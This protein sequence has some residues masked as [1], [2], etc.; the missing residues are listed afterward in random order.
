[1][2]KWRAICGLYVGWLMISVSAA[3]AENSVRFGDAA[4]NPGDTVY[5]D[6]ATENDLVLG[7]VT[8]PFHWNS[9][10]LIFDT[11]LFVRDRYQGD[12]ITLGYA[13]PSV[14]LTASLL[15]IGS[16]PN[17]GWIDRGSGV[18]ARIRF[19]IAEGAGSQWV[20]V[21]SVYTDNR[22][23]NLPG[24]QFSDYSGSR[25]IYPVVYGGFVTI[26]S[27]SG[28]ATLT[29]IPD[30]LEFHVLRNGTAPPTQVVQVR[31][32]GGPPVSWTAGNTGSWISVSP[33]SGSAPGEIQVSILSTD[34][35]VGLYPDTLVISAPAA[36]NS[37]VRLPVTLTVESATSL[38]VAPSALDFHKVIDGA[39]PANRELSLATQNGVLLNW[40]ASWSS[41]W[42]TVFPT[43]GS[44]QSVMNVG[45][46]SP[47]S[48]AG[49]YHDTIVVIA[50]EASNSPVLIPVTLSVDT[51]ASVQPRY[52]LAQNRPNPFSTYHDPITSVSYSV[53]REDQVD[54]TVYDILG[55][56]V[57][58]LLSDRVSAGTHSV[59]WDGRDDRGKTVASGH[60]FCRL[61]T[62]AG[63]ETRQ[64]VVIK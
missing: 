3:F 63:S 46:D 54:I 32:I 48:V 8:V 59:N 56:P 24:T 47:P 40:T 14:P 1:M 62:S 37:P 35:N 11:I 18:V 33:S 42:I 2:S 6:V 49:A 53:D 31:S 22:G 5:V 44:S 10:D 36:G 21:D 19:V 4:G 23:G 13:T 15:I 20:T 17:R 55:R 64:M 39:N 57:R 38:V 41:S 34:L 9:P 50:A 16:Y 60:Y 25:V 61:K 12:F 43:T 45:V 58:H 29:A 28:Q 26:G 27:P 52:A 7:A 51:A 30:R